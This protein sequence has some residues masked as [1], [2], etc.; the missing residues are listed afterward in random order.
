MKIWNSVVSGMSP[1]LACWEQVPVRAARWC[2]QT[3]RQGSGAA[4]NHSLHWRP[5]AARAARSTLASFSSMC[6]KPKQHPICSALGSQCLHP[7]D[8]LGPLEHCAILQVTSAVCMQEALMCL[9]CHEG[10]PQC[11]SGAAS[12]ALSNA[13][14]LTV[15]IKHAA[16]ASQFCR[17]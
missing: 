10:C 13:S 17:L 1:L 5:I 3:R 14:I 4:L 9:C 12:F 6:L 11:T 16:S 7:S 2:A 15:C 8:V